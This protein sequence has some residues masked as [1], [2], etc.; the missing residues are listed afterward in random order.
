MLTGNFRHKLC[1]KQKTASKK[2][3]ILPISR[4]DI[5][6]FVA[7]L[8]QRGEPP[9]TM[10]ADRKPLCERTIRNYMVA[11]DEIIAEDHRQQIPNH[12]QKQANLDGKRAIAAADHRAKGSPVLC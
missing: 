8:E 4:R 9:W 3:G 6:E 12:I 1:N 7:G 11:A 10:D 5:R 2:T